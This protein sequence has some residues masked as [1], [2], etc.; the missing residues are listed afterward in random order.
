M[1][2]YEPHLS[3]EEGVISENMK[4]LIKTLLGEE[5]ESL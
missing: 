5:I 3:K 2:P 4:V 1:N